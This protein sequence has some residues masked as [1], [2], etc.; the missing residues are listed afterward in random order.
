[1]EYSFLRSAIEA[2]LSPALAAD[3]VR[4]EGIFTAA[5]SG[6]PRIWT[7]ADCCPAGNHAS[8]RLEDKSASVVGVLLVVGL[9]DAPRDFNLT[10]HVWCESANDANLIAW[11]EKAVSLRQLRNEACKHAQA[12]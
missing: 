11:S 6:L 1:M 12:G 9:E 7:N 5:V 4:T 3:I 2:L 10:C 8:R